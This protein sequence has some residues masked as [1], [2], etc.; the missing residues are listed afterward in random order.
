[1]SAALTTIAIVVA[2]VAIAIAP[3]AFALVTATAAVGPGRSPCLAAR[4]GRYGGFGLQL[5]PRPRYG[6]DSTGF[7]DSKTVMVSF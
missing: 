1:M 7:R 5:A 4:K 2:T 6:L 3:A